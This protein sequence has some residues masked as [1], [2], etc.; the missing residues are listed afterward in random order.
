MQAREEHQRRLDDT[1]DMLLRGRLKR[2]IWRDSH[3]DQYGECGVRDPDVD[4]PG[5]KALR[6]KIDGA[7]RRET[8]HIRRSTGSNFL[9][10][11]VLTAGKL[12]AFTCS[13]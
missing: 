2:T 1:D 5:D 3:A 4:T 10:R 13:H 9:Y 8:P 11:P 7:D 12:K 6:E